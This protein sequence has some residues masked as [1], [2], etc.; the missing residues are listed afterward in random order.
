MNSIEKPKIESG[1]ETEDKEKKEA[2][3]SVSMILGRRY[4]DI[5]EEEKKD[6]LE[7]IETIFKS[8]EDFRE[9]L[10][11]A[12]GSP[13]NIPDESIKTI[14]FERP[15]NP[16]EIEIINIINEKTNELRKKFGLSLLNVSPENIY[17][18][19]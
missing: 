1:G 4:E 5:S 17:I 12:Y 15:K 6:V 14:F 19:P 8:Q 11:E 3:T 13:E 7:N 16:E 9:A 2:F 18:I 10:M